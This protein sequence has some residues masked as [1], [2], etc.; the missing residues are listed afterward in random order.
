MA[1]LSE[2]LAVSASVLVDT[3][4]ADAREEDGPASCM[5]CPAD[6]ARVESGAAPEEKSSPPD[7]A[8]ALAGTLVVPYMR[9]VRMRCAAEDGVCGSSTSRL[10]LPVMV[11]LTAPASLASGFDLRA[12]EIDSRVCRAGAEYSGGTEW[13][14]AV[15]R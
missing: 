10:G 12:G 9:F 11:S 15:H 8:A 1:V 7:E 13:E 5:N 2:S 4:P 3:S 14:V 6:P